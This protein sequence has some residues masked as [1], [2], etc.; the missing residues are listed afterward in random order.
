MKYQELNQNLKKKS[1]GELTTFRIYPGQY[2]H[3]SLSVHKSVHSGKIFSYLSVHGKYQPLNMS[4]L[5][6]HVYC[7][8]KYSRYNFVLTVVSI[9][10][11]FS[12]LIVSSISKCNAQ[13]FNERK[14]MSES[15]WST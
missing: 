5:G 4:K 14:S 11:L 1:F 15:C 13:T 12:D 8:E 3:G 6:R 9:S 7:K 2:C 10:L